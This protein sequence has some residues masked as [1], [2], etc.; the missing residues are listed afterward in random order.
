MA[1][2]GA[3]E[4][5][6]DRILDKAKS[7]KLTRPF[8]SGNVSATMPNA[9]T[10]RLRISGAGARSAANDWVTSCAQKAGGANRRPSPDQSYILID[11]PLN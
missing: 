2:T 4:A 6:I 9:N 11:V 3:Q 7:G 5:L 8:Q 1:L 10:L